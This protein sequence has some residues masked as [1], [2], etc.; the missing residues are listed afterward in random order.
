MLRI[1]QVLLD[2]E[3]SIRILWAD[4][5]TAIW[6]DIYLETA[7]PQQTRVDDIESRIAA[8]TLELI[9]DPFLSHV[10]Q[11]LE[12]ESTAWKKRERAW[13]VIKDIA[14]DEQIYYP[15]TRQ[16]L[17][18]QSIANFQV[19]KQTVYRHLRRYWQRGQCLNALTPDYKNSGGAGK[20]RQARNQKLGRP[21]TISEGVGIVIT[22]D[23]ERLFRLAIDGVY[24]GNPKTSLRDAYSNALG[25]V[26]VHAQKDDPDALPTIWQFRHFYRREYQSHLVTKARSTP[27][28][29]AKDI[30]PL[31]STST[32]EVL[33]PGS[34]YQ[35]DATIADVYLVS[36]TERSRI[37]GR[38]VIYFV[39]DVFSRMVTGLYVGF[40]GPSWVSA[41]IALGSTVE[42]KVIY[43]REMGISIEPEDW[44]TQGLPD[45][46][47]ADR[48]E[49]LGRHIEVLI[50]AF[51]VKIENA[52]AYRGDAK[53]I[54]ERYFKTIQAKFKPYVDGV[55][56]GEIGKKR[57]GSDYRLDATLTLSEFKKIIVHCV[58]WHNRY[59]ANSKYDRDEDMPTELPAVPLQLWNW[60][61]VNRTGRLRT[62]PEDRVKINLLPYKSATVSEEGIKLFGCFYTCSE[63]VEQGWFNRKGARRPE[64]VIAAYDPRFADRIYLRMEH[65]A[66]YWTCELTDRSRR[67]RGMSFWDVWQITKEERKTTAMAEKTRDTTRSNLDETIEAIAR[68]AR[69]NK[70]NCD[71]LTKA[72]RLGSIRDNRQQEKQQERRDSQFIPKTPQKKTPATVIPLRR[73][74]EEDYSFPDMLDELFGEDEND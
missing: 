2:R 5:V 17:I 64:S 61:I 19:T 1:N 8:G 3:M 40:E 38:P 65:D 49:M 10:L 27:I 42:D 53:G 62:Y 47:L 16:K 6:I 33:G 9:E 51:R 69:R 70:P 36:E 37:V 21:R 31:H 60:G 18:V 57:G 28:V 35:I 50:G 48:G 32:A 58:L 74:Q 54:V 7:L 24:L 43:C 55:V 73:P 72:E 22:L 63:A 29:Y 25:L 52:S 23:I 15:T 46:I 34:R 56:M 71:G 66:T 30:R 14:N 13:S 59:H 12:K 4:R 26:K 11:S 41:M 68:N 20:R 39:I 45:A 67:F 44:P